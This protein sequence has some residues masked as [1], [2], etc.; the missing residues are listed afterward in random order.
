MNKKAAAEASDRMLG[1]RKHRPVSSKQ[2][3]RDK[4]DKLR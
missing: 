3:K 4:E 1:A 2:D